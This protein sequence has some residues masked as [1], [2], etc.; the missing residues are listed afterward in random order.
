VARLRDAEA[1]EAGEMANATEVTTKADAPPALVGGHAALDFANTAAWHASDAPRESLTT[2]G[3]F[4]WWAEHA[5]VLAAAERARLAGAADRAPA[6]AARVLRRA[7]ALREAFYRA[8]A[9]SAAGRVAADDDLRAVHAARVD[10]LAHAALRPAAGV[11]AGYVV[12]W[13][14]ESAGAPDARL[15]VP[16]WRLAHAAAEL[17]TSGDV[18]RLRE[19]EGH[20]CGWLFLDRSRNRSRR[21][22]A[23]AD[24]GNRARVRRHLDRRRTGA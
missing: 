20:P 6:A 5:G 22:C 4:L 21:W 23:S 7:L 14:V 17:L 1:E 2:Y 19:C 12:T 18:G 11:G 10:A 9:A 13:P 3:Q 16:L 8:A 24:C 15:E